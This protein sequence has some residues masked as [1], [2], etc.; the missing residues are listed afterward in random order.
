MGSPAGQAS[1]SEHD[2]GHHREYSVARATEGDK[3]RS[4]QLLL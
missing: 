4:W 3:K 2:F 1:E